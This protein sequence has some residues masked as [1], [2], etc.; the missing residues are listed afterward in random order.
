MGQSNPS[1]KIADKTLSK[2]SL[3]HENG[4]LYIIWNVIISEPHILLFRRERT[5]MAT[6]RK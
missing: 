4:N 1:P 2:I 5:D 6:N 3:N